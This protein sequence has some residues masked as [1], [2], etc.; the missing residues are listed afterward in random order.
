MRGSYCPGDDRHGPQHHV[1]V[2][3]RHRS[4]RPDLA[5]SDAAGFVGSRRKSKEEVLPCHP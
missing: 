2:S 1:V 3:G 4:V 5:G